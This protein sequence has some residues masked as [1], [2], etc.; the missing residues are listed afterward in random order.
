MARFRLSSPL[1]AFVCPMGSLSLLSVGFACHGK[2]IPPFSPFRQCVLL[3][4]RRV[5]LVS[6]Y[7][8]CIDFFRFF[9]RACVHFTK[10]RIFPSK[11]LRCTSAAGSALSGAVFCLPPRTVPEPPFCAKKSYSFVNFPRNK[12]N[13]CQNYGQTV[14]PCATIAFVLSSAARN[15]QKLHTTLEVF[16][17]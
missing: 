3:Q 1:D 12:K 7:P 4:G 14:V 10:R 17:C 13:L 5:F 16:S 8:V 9:R 11:K 15:R 6:Y 2:R